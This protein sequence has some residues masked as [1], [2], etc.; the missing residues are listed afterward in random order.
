MPAQ[1]KQEIGTLPKDEKGVTSL[2]YCIL[3]GGVGFL[4]VLGSFQYIGPGIS[5]RLGNAF[6]PEIVLSGDGICAAHNKGNKEGTGNCGVGLGG[7]GGNGTPNEGK[8]PGPDKEKT[9]HPGQ[10]NS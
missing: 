4:I 9:D 2:E 3:L 6:K 1:L 7:G 10:G 8:G 5:D